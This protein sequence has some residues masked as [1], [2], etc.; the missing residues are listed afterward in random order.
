MGSPVEAEG[1]VCQKTPIK[2]KISRGGE[3]ESQEK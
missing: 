3:A 1:W 2:R